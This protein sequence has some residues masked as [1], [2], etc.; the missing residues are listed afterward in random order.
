MGYLSLKVKVRI[1][2]LKS[3]D[4]YDVGQNYLGLV[5]FVY[6]Q[7]GF[8]V[9]KQDKDI[10]IQVKDNIQYSIW[11]GGVIVMFILGLGW[12]TNEIFEFDYFK[13]KGE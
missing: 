5:I 4:Q 6:Y 2:D 8:L 12:Y 10:F 7:V 13:D 1:N 9:I 11:I 3:R